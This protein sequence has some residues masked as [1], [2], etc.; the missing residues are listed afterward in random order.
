MLLLFLISA[1][2]KPAFSQ[3]TVNKISNQCPEGY[4]VDDFGKCT[5][6]SYSPEIL[7]PKSKGQCPKHFSVDAGGGYCKK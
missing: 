7:S 4:F 5:T 6:F 3:R 1:E 2:S